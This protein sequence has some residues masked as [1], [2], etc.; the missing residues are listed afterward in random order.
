MN[1]FGANEIIDPV[2]STIRKVAGYLN[3]SEPRYFLDA[4]E[5]F[6]SYSDDFN[7]HPIDLDIS[8][9]FPLRSVLFEYLARL[10]ELAHQNWLIKNINQLNFLGVYGSEEWMPQIFEKYACNLILFTYDCWSEV[11]Q[12]SCDG[13]IDGLIYSAW[14]KNV[15]LGVQTKLYSG[16]VPI[17]DIRE[18]YGALVTSSPKLTNGLFFTSR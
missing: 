2:N 4:A 1:L 10:H 5:E 18:F 15:I 14:K 8:V 11:T 12:A 7:F 9:G 3:T 13:G 16:S 6:R 17:S